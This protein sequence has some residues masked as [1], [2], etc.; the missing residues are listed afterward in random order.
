MEKQS[1]FYLI[2]GFTVV[3]AFLAINWLSASIYNVV[4]QA[5]AATSSNVTVSA[6]IA[7]SIVCAN[8]TTTVV[9][10][11]IDSASIYTVSNV[12]SSMSCSTAS[13][14]CTFY[15]NDT[16]SGAGAPGLYKSAAPAKLIG[17]ANSAYADTATLVAG[18]EGYGIQAATTTAG[19]GGALGI[20]SRYLQTGNAVGGFETTSTIA[21]SSTASLSGKEILTTYKVAASSTTNSGSYAD[22]VTYS[23]LSN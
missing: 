2:G 1:N 12:S 8:S 17:S 14:G 22:T 19:S 15:I 11:T 21:A 18:T 9:F 7:D 13:T 3:V 10:G 20:V 23:C 16:G 6:S 4:N 5:V